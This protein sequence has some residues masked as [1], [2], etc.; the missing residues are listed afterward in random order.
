VQDESPSGGPGQE[1]S[2]QPPSDANP[3]TDIVDLVN[4]KKIVAVSQGS[5]IQKVTVRV[6]KLVPDALTL[7]IPVGTYF[8]SGKT[9]VQNMVA[10]AESTFT[11]TGDG[12]QSLSVAAASPNVA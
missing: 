3:N 10:T 4:Q 1:D 9:S 6:S 2:T 8:V 5:G 12:W 11:L 7:R